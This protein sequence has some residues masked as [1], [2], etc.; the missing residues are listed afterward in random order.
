MYMWLS[1]VLWRQGSA[2]RERQV[3]RQLEAVLVTPASRV[4]LLFGPVGAS[5]LLTLGLFAVAGVALRVGFGVEF[6]ALE[7]L[8][9]LVV[10]VVATPAISGLSALFS[11]LVQLFRGLF[12]VFCGTTF[13]IAAL[14]GWAHAV[15]LGCLP[16]T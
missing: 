15:A 12:T 5:L 10:V 14:P 11:A 16:P 2:L 8:R 6:S 9:A 1:L 13:P 3:Q 7:A 4:A